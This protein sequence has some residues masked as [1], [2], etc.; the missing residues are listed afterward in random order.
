MSSC[1]LSRRR[2][3]L[4]ITIAIL[5]ASRK[6]IRKTHLLSSVSMSYGQLSRYLEFLKANGFLEKSGDLYKTGERG[7]E[8][9]EEFESSPL[10]R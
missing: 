9:I 3:S 8:L 7:L 2:E 10:T 5:K 1:F 6:G 4:S